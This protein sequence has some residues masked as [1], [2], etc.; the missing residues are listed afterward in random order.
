MSEQSYREKFQEASMQRHKKQKKVLVMVLTVFIVA[1]IALAV[2][3]FLMFNFVP[4]GDVK[5]SP[6]SQLPGFYG[7]L[8]SV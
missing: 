1:V 5:L 4:I 7:C 8:F 3:L 2:I 6:T